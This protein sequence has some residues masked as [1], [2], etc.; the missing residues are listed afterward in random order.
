MLKILITIEPNLQENCKKKNISL[1]YR[2]RYLLT[3]LMSY[4]I[5]ELLPIMV[6]SWPS[7][8]IENSPIDKKNMHENSITFSIH[9]LHTLPESR[10]SHVFMSWK[11]SLRSLFTYTDYLLVA[12]R[13]H[14]EKYWNT[15]IY[16][17]KHW[18]IHVMYLLVILSESFKFFDM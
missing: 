16:L 13:L 9:C 3:T 1:Q 6:D 17:L 12:T 11:N 2:S 8:N 5:H 7:Q 14:R 15:F 18:S 4:C 10:V